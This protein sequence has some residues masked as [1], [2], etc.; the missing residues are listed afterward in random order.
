MPIKDEKPTGKK[1]AATE[2]T[3]KGAGLADG[4]WVAYKFATEGEHDED[5]EDETWDVVIPT[6]D[7]VPALS[8]EGNGAGVNGDM[9]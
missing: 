6:Y 1:S 9:K 2:D 4:A 7:D 8:E 5:L 3:P